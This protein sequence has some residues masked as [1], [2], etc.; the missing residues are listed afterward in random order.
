M[1]FSFS[2]SRTLPLFAVAFAPQE[3]L[4]QIRDFKDL[5][6]FQKQMEHSSKGALIQP[7]K[8]G[9]GWYRFRWKEST[10]VASK[11]AEV[12]RQSGVNWAEP[13]YRIDIDPLE[14]EN[15]KY[16]TPVRD[17]RAAEQWGYS[18]IHLPEVWQTGAD[19]SKGLIVAVTDTGVDWDHPDLK[20][21]LY[22]NAKEIPD[23]GIDDDGNGLIDD[24][25]GWDFEAESPDSRDDYGHG[26]H[27]AGTIGAVGGNGVGVSG[28]CWNVTLLPVK[29]MKKGSGWGS[30][31]IEA[32]HYSTMV[33]ARVINASWGGIGESKALEDVLKEARDHG[34]VFVTAS[35]NAKYD[36]DAKPWSPGTYLLENMINVAATDQNDVL[37][38]FSN[39]GLK[40]VA[41]AAPGVQILSTSYDGKYSLKDGTSMAS[42]HVAGLAALLLSQRPDLTPARLK[43]LLMDTAVKLPS[44]TGKVA[45][46]GRV[47]AQAALAALSQIPAASDPAI[48][49]EEDLR[50]GP[51][52]VKIFSAPKDFSP[53]RITSTPDRAGKASVRFVIGEGVGAFSVEGLSFGVST[54]SG[55]ST[56]K[57]DASGVAEIP[58]C[59]Q[60]ESLS[61][62][63][64]LDERDRFRV[65]NGRDTYSVFFRV[66]CGAKSE[67]GFKSDSIGGQALGIWRVGTLALHK[68]DAAVGLSF[69]RYPVSFVWPGNGDYYTSD[70]V[71][72]TRGDQW[73]VVGHELGHAL[74]DQGHIGVF[75]GGPHKIDECYGDDL[76]LSEGWA[77]FYSG[78][79]NVALDDPD[80]K[81]PYM[82]PRRAPIR[83]ENIPDD[84]CRG[85]KNEWRVS[86]YL[87]DLI[88][89]HV[90]GETASFGFAD[91]WKTLSGTR[92]AS[93]TVLASTLDHAGWNHAALEEVWVK[94]LAAKDLAATGLAA[95][96]LAK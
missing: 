71:T 21:N 48:L 10:S 69:W 8:F 1:S 34:V 19:C 42:P 70:T 37:A 96:D 94:D 44:L 26:T 60:G 79:L 89:T 88:D 7:L 86:S 23:N 29:W 72:L 3:L 54:A 35:G 83:L 62:V 20:A 61:L 17:P 84:V 92:V 53:D 2:W 75:G 9:H 77:T 11:K 22:T 30:D 12:L 41:V 78:W 82:T 67:A 14:S 32:I 50:G 90:D 80:A 68:M 73:D 51:A 65:T 49:D 87:W 13:N 66:P 95:K 4:V 59:T 81:L 40:S 25:H 38:K 58:S 47:D 57:T 56:L 91:L 24:V 76:A 16:T 15:E 74:Y 33:G 28:V 63:I 31:A 64:D 27:V 52:P 39:Y 36:V 85:P 43:Q 6:Q 18:K 5:A 46:G 55:R 45:S 93:A